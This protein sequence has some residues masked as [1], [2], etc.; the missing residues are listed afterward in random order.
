MELMD[1]FID[2]KKIE[3]LNDLKESFLD[4]YFP[5][6]GDEPEPEQEKEA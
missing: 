3:H 5:R 1:F 2:P 6:Q 4:L